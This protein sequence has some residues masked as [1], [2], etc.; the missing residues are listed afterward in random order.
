MILLCRSKWLKIGIAWCWYLSDF[1]LLCNYLWRAISVI[2]DKS[3]RRSQAKKWI[4]SGSLVDVEWDH[5]INKSTGTGE[6]R[7]W[8][9][10]QGQF[11]HKQK[12]VF[13]TMNNA[14]NQSKGNVGWKF[15]LQDIGRLNDLSWCL[16]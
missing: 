3:R 12:N 2:E 1:L 10:G 4:W 7:R 8:R 9:R 6:M 15:T 11:S 5:I 13:E 14:Y 16:E